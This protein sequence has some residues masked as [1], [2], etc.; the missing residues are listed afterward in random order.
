MRYTLA[1]LVQDRP[2]VL[3]HIAGL[4]SRRRYNIKSIAAG[5]TE[6][7]EITRI[8]IVV[9]CNEDKVDQVMK[10][11]AKLVDV[12]KVSDLTAT[13]SITRDMALIKVHALPEKRTQI[14]D[15][16]NIFRAG[17]VDIT[18]DTMVIEATGEAEKINALCEVMS[19]HGII[20]IARTGVIAVSR[21][22]V[23]IKA[24]PYRE[25]GIAADDQ[26]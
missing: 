14:V 9:D 26:R 12:V 5:A 25:D 6:E 21:G 3:T 20:E 22:A 17:I 2:S 16:V 4:I 15:I 8:T 1:L 13:P 11:L 24:L 18:K 10:Q 19:E 23:P 7:P